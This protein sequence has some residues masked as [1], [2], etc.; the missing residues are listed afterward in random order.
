MA[1]R[2]IKGRLAGA[3]RGHLVPAPHRGVRFQAPATA[4]S[5]LSPGYVRPND[6][7]GREAEDED[8]EA[9]HPATRVPAK[10]AVPTV[11]TS[12]PAGKRRQSARRIPDPALAI[13]VRPLS[14][15]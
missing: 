4:N 12:G 1:P 5:T 7:Q 10:I 9:I 6:G 11:T 2:R 13:P 8:R 14:S 3:S 15:A